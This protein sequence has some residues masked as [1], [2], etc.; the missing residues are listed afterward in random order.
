MDFDERRC[1]IEVEKAGKVKMGKLLINIKS[2]Y[3][4]MSKTEKKIADYLIHNQNRNT[5]MTITELS[6]ATGAS[7][8]T[9]VRFA[10]KVGCSGYQQLKIAL[11]KEEQH[12]ANKSLSESDT[13][14]TIYV[15]TSDDIYSSLLKTRDS[16]N[17]ENFKIA[18]NLINK[19]NQIFI[20]GV[21]NSYAVCLDAYHKFLRLGFNI[22]P[23]GDS[24]FQVI[25]ACKSDANTL[26]IVVSHS[27]CTKDIL[28]TVAIA[29][30]HNAKIFAV[31]GDRTSLLAKNADAVLTTSSEEINYRMLGLSSRYAQLAIFDTLYSYIVLHSDKARQTVEEI[32]NIILAKRITKKQ[33]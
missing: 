17:E 12:I 14:S 19:A 11:A 9:I 21:G 30:N 31:T 5:P 16:I 6:E 22:E 25:A 23:I 15:K 7:E 26:F 29:K 18:Y 28:E 8:A 27:G 1:K 10:K 13:F 33:K 4:R 2:A 24:H 32:E 3:P 20:I